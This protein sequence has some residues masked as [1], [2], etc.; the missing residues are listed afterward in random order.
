VPTSL[1]QLVLPR[2]ELH[3]F[4]NS[5]VFLPMVIAMVYHLRPSRAEAAMA[6]CTCAPKA[7]ASA[8]AAPAI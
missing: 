8:V 5:V 7:R 1:L 3:L 4:Y 2:V 6:T